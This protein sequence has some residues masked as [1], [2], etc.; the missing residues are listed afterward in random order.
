VVL[1]AKF[2]F[3]V[4]AALDMR[5]KQEDEAKQAL[6][7]AETRKREAEAR[8]DEA[9][10]ALQSTLDRATQAEHEAGDVHARQWYRNWIV[11]QRQEL[12]RR[13][14]VVA[15]RDAD[16]RQATAVAQDAYKKRRI[17]ERLRD[18]SHATFLDA[19]RREE[20]KMFDEIG[21]LRFSIDKHGGIS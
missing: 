19:E 16:V 3:R 15:A 4:Q 13:R 2:V 6:A 14:T 18:R 21:S 10:Q 17:L 7:S 5:R 1:M 12:E 20:Q 11:A 8:R 9:H